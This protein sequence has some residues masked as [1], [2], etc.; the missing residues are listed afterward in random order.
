MTAESGGPGDHDG[1]READYDGDP[2]VKV[3][4]EA[5][6]GLHN[7]PARNDAPGW[8]EAAQE[9]AKWEQMEMKD[10]IVDIGRTMCNVDEAAFSDPDMKRFYQACWHC[11]VNLCE[12]NKGVCEQCWMCTR[13]ELIEAEYHPVGQ[14]KEGVPIWDRN[15]YINHAEFGHVPGS[16]T[17]WRPT[18]NNVLLAPPRILMPYIPENTEPTLVCGYN[19]SLKDSTAQKLSDGW[20]KKWHLREDVPDNYLVP[21]FRPP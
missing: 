4:E 18:N 5:D 11:E 17:A 3:D 12:F 16:V 20:T 9:N 2:E 19:L 6:S 7:D 10:R 13:R 15:L 21:R 14:N 1:D 8:G